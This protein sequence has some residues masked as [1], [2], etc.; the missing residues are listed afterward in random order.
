MIIRP[1]QITSIFIQLSWIRGHLNSRQRLYHSW[2]TWPRNF[3]IWKLTSFISVRQK[4]YRSLFQLGAQVSSYL[5]RRVISPYR[6]FACSNFSNIRGLWSDVLRIL[7]TQTCLHYLT[8]SDEAIPDG[9]AEFKCC[10]P[11]RTLTNQDKLWQGLLADEIDYIVSDHS[12]C[13]IDLK[14]NRTLM[15]AWG[16]IGGLGLGI[17]LIWTEGQRRK[18]ENLPGWILKWFCERPAKQVKIDHLK[19]KIEVGAECDLCVFDPNSSFEVDPFCSVLRHAKR[20]IENEI[21]FIFKIGDHQRG[22][23]Q[24]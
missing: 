18:I 4:R 17:S 22:S 24:E 6:D 8:L 5:W 9:R 7:H 12:P 16:G 14:E 19:G 20:L 13:T 15:E 2:S 3:P 11:I 21:L 1:T 10:P 23:F